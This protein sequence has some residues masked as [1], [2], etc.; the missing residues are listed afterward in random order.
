MIILRRMNNEFINNYS[1]NCDPQLTSVTLRIKIIISQK[2]VASTGSKK[3]TTR[4]I[5]NEPRKKYAI[6]VLSYKVLH[7]SGKLELKINL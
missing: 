4:N 7:D 5:H 2:I 3:N 6:K 1:I